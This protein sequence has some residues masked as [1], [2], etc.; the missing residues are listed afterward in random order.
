MKIRLETG[1]RP[2]LIGEIAAQHGR[3]Y[4]ANW[5]FGTFF[6]AKVA[7]E[8]AGF[9][10]RARDP[11][12]ILSAWDGDS[13][14]GSLILDFHDPEAQGLAHLRWFVVTRPG[15]GLGARMM[16]A[17]MARL[18]AE[19]A[20]CF[21]TTFA[22]LD[23]ARALYDRHG[24]VLTAEHEAESWGVLVREQRFDRAATRP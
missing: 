16:D 1:P 4:A 11:D 23:A 6:E 5:G 22:G 10:E 7:R 19:A 24:F 21:L 2:G 13:F 20:A 17:A 12:L 18:D 9:M 8:C 3:Y 15:A 14:A